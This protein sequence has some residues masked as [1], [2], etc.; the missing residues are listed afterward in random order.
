[1]TRRIAAAVIAL[2]TMLSVGLAGCSSPGDGYAVLER[3][4]LQPADALPASLPDNT[5]DAL[6]PESARFAGEHEG[7]SLWLARGQERDALIC[8]LAYRT[9]G[10]FV[11]G[12][13]GLGGVRTSFGGGTFEVVQDG[14]P[15]PEG[16]V[17]V[18]ENLYAI[19]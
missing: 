16:A 14:I 2:G 4:P 6:V 11:Q 7:V 3:R 18:S 1:M 15:G 8:L 9:D 10:D 17:R 12:C 19:R 13:S 5:V